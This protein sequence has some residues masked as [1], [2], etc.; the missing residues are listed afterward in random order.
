MND[1]LEMVLFP[2]SSLARIQGLQR[3]PEMGRSYPMPQPRDKARSRDPIERGS[4]S[5]D[6]VDQI[7]G[8]QRQYTRLELYAIYREM[9]M[10]PLI[11]TVLDAYAEDATQRDFESGRTVWATAKNPEV[12]KIVTQCLERMEIEDVAFAIVRSMAKFGDEF[13]RV[14]AAQNAGILHIRG[15]DPWDIARIEDEHGRLEAFSPCDAEGRPTNVQSNSVPFYKALHF[16]L[17]GIR[18]N[19]IYGGSILWGSREKWRQLQL[20]EDQIVMQRLLRRP[21]RLLIL[22]DVGGMPLA[23][24]Y[25]ACKEWEDR[26]YKEHNVD[27]VSGIFTSQGTPLHEARDLILPLGQDNNTRIENLPAT[28]GNDLFRDFEI[29]L[30]RLLGGLRMPKGYFGFEGAYEP[31]MSLGKQDVRFAKTA[32]RIQRAFLGEL[33]RACMIDLAFHNLDPFRDENAFDLH[34]A[35]VSA[36]AEIER[37]ELLQMRVDLMDRL[38]RLGEDMGFNKEAW[39][40]YVLEEVGRVPKDLV[41]KL[42][43]QGEGAAAEAVEALSEDPK[44]LAGLALIQEGLPTISSRSK[45]GGMKGGVEEAQQALSEAVKRLKESGAEDE[46]TWAPLKTIPAGSDAVRAMHTERA[47]RR[48]QV[49]RGLSNVPE[50]A[51]S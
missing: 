42:T 41:D 50:R 2:W 20:I 22:M 17:R 6:W 7:I 24:A 46:K 11:M 18:R 10:D 43:A 49:I 3:R 29:I 16:R 37:A 36:F 45:R 27:P 35:P 8:T 15:Y 25:E 28:T 48:L 34:M 4:R 13:E 47:E 39:I 26:I 38:A 9:D 1:M 44:A 21:D 14:V 51:A 23:E 31:N 19:D 40:P 12:R 30:G 32:T 5:G 33:V